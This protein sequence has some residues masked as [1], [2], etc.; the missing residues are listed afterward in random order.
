ML[1]LDEMTSIQV[2]LCGEGGE[3]LDDE[4]PQINLLC[5][6]RPNF[7]LELQLY[8]LEYGVAAVTGKLFLLSGQIKFAVMDYLLPRVL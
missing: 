5:I 8:L 1:S 7:T 6:V 2:G 3:I 4:C